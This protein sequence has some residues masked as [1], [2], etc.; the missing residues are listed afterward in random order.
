MLAVVAAALGAMPHAAFAWGAEGHQLIAGIARG[1]LTA[2]ARQQVDAMLA[3][4]TDTLTPHDMASQAT[5]ADRYRGAGHPETASWHFVD[6][7]LDKPDLAAA[8]FGFPPPASPAS[9]GPQDDCVVDKVEEFQ[10][11]LANPATA[12]AE[13]LLALKYLLHFIGDIHQPLHASDNHDRGGNCVRLAFGG[14]RTTN[15]HSYWDTTVVTAL[16]SDPQ[17]VARQLAAKITPA[18]KSAWEQ[19]APRAWAQ[20]SYTVARQSVY[21]FGSPPGCARDQAPVGLPPGYDRAAQ[22][23]AAIQLE[24]AGVRLAL[25]LNRALGR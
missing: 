24:R 5:W 18:Q 14:P 12:P 4:D 23:A 6:I 22:A 17:V 9:A 11:E 16:G 2:Q 8:C 15:L 25:V 13:R 7:E 10:A 20:E 3:A 21:T 19:G 1:Y